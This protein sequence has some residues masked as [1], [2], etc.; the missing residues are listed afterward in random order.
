MKTTT[1]RLFKAPDTNA[2]KWSLWLI[3]AM[4]LFF[5]LGS[6]F[7]NTLYPSIPS[8]DSIL[9]DIALRPSLS[10]FMFSG[11]AAGVL[12]FFSGL[13]AILRQKERSIFVFAS[14]LI[15]SLMLLFLIGEV[16]FPH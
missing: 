7:M 13:L 16:V 8:G 12:A 6:L 4:P 5:L 14:T 11:M 9:Q 3:V 10:I 15:G 2:G 1:V